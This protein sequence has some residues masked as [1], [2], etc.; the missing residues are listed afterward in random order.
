[1]KWW[2]R[3]RYWRANWAARPSVTLLTPVEI[4]ISVSVRAVAAA[5]YRFAYATT[6]RRNSEHPLLTIPR[7]VLWEK[8]SVGAQLFSGAVLDCQIHH[9]FDR[10]AE[11]YRQP[12]AF[13]QESGRS[14]K[15]S[16]PATLLVQG[17]RRRRPKHRS[18][19]ERP[20]LIGSIV[21]LFL[22]YANTPFVL[23]AADIIHPAAI[24]GAGALLALLSETLFGGRKFVA[25]WPE[26]GLLL[27]LPG[28]GGALLSHR[29]LARPR[30]GR[31]LRPRQDVAGLL[32]PGERRPH[33]SPGTRRDVDHGHRRIVF[34]AVGTIRN[35]R[36]GIL[37]EGRAAWVGIFANPN[38]VAY[39]MVILMPFA[40]YLAMRSGW[41]LRAFSSRSPRCLLW[42]ACG[43]SP[44]ADS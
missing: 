7:T 26:G 4:S 34:P 19:R 17:E 33:R 40:A 39:A 41:L 10:F 1:M 24:V 15:Q 2:G 20:F 31:A 35:F 42:A 8:S 28:R 18:Q 3:A 6:P 11:G 22:L 38:E 23:P 36:A 5:G 30:R 13:R 25:A 21:F 27:S 14:P 37:Q 43:R 9:A 44:A 16:P 29:P 12:H 32:L